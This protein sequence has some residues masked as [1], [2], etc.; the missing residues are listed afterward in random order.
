VYA[1]FLP[2]LL[3]SVGISRQWTAWLLMADHIIFRF[4]SDQT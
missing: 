3:D 1:I 4:Q 2:G